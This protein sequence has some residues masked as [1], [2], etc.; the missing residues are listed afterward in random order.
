MRLSAAATDLPP[1]P[2]TPEV[3]GELA[4]LAPMLGAS[5][6]LLNR[7]HAEAYYSGMPPPPT[8]PGNGGGSGAEGGAR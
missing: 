5:Q 6:R 8:L 7:D 1:D 4:I 3:T 2:P